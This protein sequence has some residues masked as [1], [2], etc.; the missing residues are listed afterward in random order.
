MIDAGHLWQT[1]LQLQMIVQ[2]SEEK[3]SSKMRILDRRVE[4][5]NILLIPN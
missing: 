1:T 2:C 4:D 5:Q 3:I